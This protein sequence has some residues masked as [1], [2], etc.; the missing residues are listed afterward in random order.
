M[1]DEVQL[2]QLEK[3]DQWFVTSRG[4]SPGQFLADNF[5]GNYA[6]YVGFCQDRR[7]ARETAKKMGLTEPAAL[8]VFFTEGQ[9]LGAQRFGLTERALT[10]PMVDDQKKAVSGI[11]DASKIEEKLKNWMG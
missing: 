5:S 4:L 6:L 2:S 10:G 1:G 3:E 11:L 7:H 9:L 8:P